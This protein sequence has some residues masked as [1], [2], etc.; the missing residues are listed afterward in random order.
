MVCWEGSNLQ[1]RG[2][3]VDIKQQQNASCFNMHAVDV[4]DATV[5]LLLT[6]LKSA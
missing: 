1:G 3:Q 5:P 2:Q 6:F 4:A